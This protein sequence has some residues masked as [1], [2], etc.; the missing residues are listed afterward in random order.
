MT[1]LKYFIFLLIFLNNYHFII[2]SKKFL[3]LKLNTFII[4]YHYQNF[5][6]IFIKFTYF[7]FILFF[8]I[9]L[10]DFQI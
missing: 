8:L 3:N 6:I 7:S 10:L 1:Y 2:I 4:H 5:C 9:I